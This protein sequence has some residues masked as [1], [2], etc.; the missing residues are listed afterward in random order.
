MAQLTLTGLEIDTL[1]E[2]SQVVKDD[3]HAGIAPTLNLSETSALGQVIDSTANQIRMVQEALQALYASLDPYQATGE[4]LAQRVALV[5]VT[6]LP[7]TR[8]RAWMTIT[9]AAGTYDAGTLIVHRADDP[10]VRFSN[11][12]DIVTLGGTLTDVPF[13]SEETG[14]VRA[15]A[16]TLTEIAA[17]VVGFS[18]PT[19]PEDVDLG[20]VAESDTAL[21]LRWLDQLSRAGS[22]TVDG[23]LADVLQV[24]GVTNARVYENTN[25]GTVDGI[26]GH[27]FETV[28][29]GGLD[30]D[31]AQAI[32]DSK[33]AGIQA[34]GSTTVTVTDTQGVNHPIGFSRPTDVD[35]TLTVTLTYLNGLFK[36][37]EALKL[38]IVDWADFNLAPGM[39]VIEAKLTQ[40]IME[41]PGVVDVAIEFDPPPSPG[42]N[43]V[44]SPRQIARFDTSR[45][46]VIA[47]S[48]TAV[49]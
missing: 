22:G 12:Q 13:D 4:A 44:I 24:E 7:A 46:D 21:R 49:P 31:I 28:V 1:D 5:G 6:R 16:G 15:T 40:I 9:L 23:I 2:I 17:P 38:A 3:V 39:D 33:P 37:A 34:F 47:T 10:S 43:V 30:S 26:P 11:T 27:A 18:N 32:Y 36:G 48:V 29:L 41:Q 42:P 14:P 45:I 20:Q 19:N 8:S 35:I 25:N